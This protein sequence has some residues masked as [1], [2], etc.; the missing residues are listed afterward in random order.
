MADLHMTLW[1]Q[2]LRLLVPSKASVPGRIRMSKHPRRFHELQQKHDR[3][4]S[5]YQRAVN[6]WAYIM[7]DFA[8]QSL[9]LNDFAV[10][11]IQRV[12]QTFPETVIVR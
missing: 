12:N 7:G 10:L 9:P 1:T 4:F 3:F 11:T 8:Q 2:T 5:S 6:G